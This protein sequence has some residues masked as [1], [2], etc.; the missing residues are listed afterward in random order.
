MLKLFRRLEPGVNLELAIGRFLTQ[1]CDFPHTPQPW[2][3]CWYECVTASFTS[4]Y[5]MVAKDAVFLPKER[6]GLQ[7]LF[8]A[9]ALEKAVY[10]LGYELNNRPAWVRIALRGSLHSIR[11][12]EI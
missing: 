5:L 11:A 4:G 12:G 2:R 10:E 7:V 3:R 6:R 1:K 9:Y 8:D